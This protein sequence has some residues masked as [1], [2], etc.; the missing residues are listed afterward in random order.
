MD[1][2]TIDGD[3]PAI[4]LPEL[5]STPVYKASFTADGRHVVVLGGST[6]Q[7]PADRGALRLEPRRTLAATWGDGA[8]IFLICPRC[9]GDDQQALIWVESR[10]RARSRAWRRP[11]EAPAGADIAAIVLGSSN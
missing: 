4:D 11:V 5:R 8:Q 1:D 3:A 6:V 7:G 2:A 10:A 9:R